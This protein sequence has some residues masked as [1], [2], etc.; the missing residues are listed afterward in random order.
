MTARYS[1]QILICLTVTGI[2][3]VL[4]PQEGEGS[5]LQPI[6]AVTVW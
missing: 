4:N 1:L 2:S 3:A 5:F 6:W